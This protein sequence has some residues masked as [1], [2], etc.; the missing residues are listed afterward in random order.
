MKISTDG[1][2]NWIEVESL[3]VSQEIPNTFNEQE[4]VEIELL[5]NFT[6]ESLTQCLW[7][8]N[9]NEGTVSQTYVEVGDALALN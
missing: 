6:K 8:N 2:L 7:I 1:G 3:Q 5:F 4:D 9:V